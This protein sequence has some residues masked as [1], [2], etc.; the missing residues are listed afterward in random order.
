MEMSA[1][2]ILY[3][4]EAAV[5]LTLLLLP[6]FRGGRK[7]VEPEKA[8]EV[9]ACP[10]CGSLNISALKHTKY[11]LEKYGSMMGVYTCQECGYEGL[12]LMLDNDSEY[13]KYLKKIGKG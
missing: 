4:G 12:P 13:R 7:Q 1:E 8:R 3:A 11:W 6:K 5:I 10:R 9:T 2:F